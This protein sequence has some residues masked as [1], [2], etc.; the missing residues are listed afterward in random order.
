[1]KYLMLYENY[2]TS[3]LFKDLH[4]IGMSGD[5][6]MIRI[7]KILPASNE[8]MEFARITFPGVNAIKG[9]IKEE[10]IINDLLINDYEIGLFHSKDRFGG[11]KA[12]LKLKIEASTADNLDKQSNNLSKFIDDLS[13]MFS[14]K[15]EIVLEIDGTILKSKESGKVSQSA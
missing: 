2:I 9:K 4:N 10:M 15:V 8:P 11:K 1:M 7:F 3:D 6:A 14:E 12:R 5:R 13:G